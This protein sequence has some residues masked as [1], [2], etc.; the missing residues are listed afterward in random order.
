MRIVD[1]A[2]VLQGTAYDKIYVLK[3]LSMLRRH[4]SHQVRL[5]VFTEPERDL[6][7]DVVRHDLIPWAVRRGWWYK[8]QMFDPAHGIGP[9]LYLDLDTVIVN[10]LDW[11]FDLDPVIFWITRDFRRIWKPRNQDN[12]SSVMYWD[13]QVWGEIWDLWQQQDI[14][15][16]TQQFRGDQDYLDSVLKSPKKQFFPQETMVSWRWQVWDGGLD[17]R[18]RKP[19]HPDSGPILDPQAKIAVF[20][21]RPKP[22]EIQHPWIAKYWN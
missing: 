17:P 5:H 3:L 15:Y 13:P 8:M 19:L 7:L 10:S 22:H 21:G 16:V 1:C 11:I 12:N 18:T 6:D 2:C 4:I 14:G 20:H 9:M